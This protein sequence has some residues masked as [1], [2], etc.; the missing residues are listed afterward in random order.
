MKEKQHLKAFTAP[1]LDKRRRGNQQ[2]HNAA[3]GRCVGGLF[4]IIAQA[5]AIIAAIRAAL[6]AMKREGV[7]ASIIKALSAD[8]AANNAAAAELVTAAVAGECNADVARLPG[9]RPDQVNFA[10]EHIGVYPPLIRF[11]NDIPLDGLL[12]AG[13]PL[14]ARLRG[15]ILQV[16]RKRQITS[17]D[18]A[19]VCKLYTKYTNKKR[20]QGQ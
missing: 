7:P 8:I 20:R 1:T 6:P 9:F 18:V 17:E 3:A 13:T 12:A 15:A 5:F 19:Y 11:E 4:T 2:H 16:S 10:C 14:P